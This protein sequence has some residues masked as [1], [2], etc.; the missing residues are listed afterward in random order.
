MSRCLPTSLAPPIP[1]L[2]R[3]P[4]CRLESRLAPQAGQTGGSST[5]HSSPLQIHSHAGS[6]LQTTL[7]LQM[8]LRS[9][10]WCQTAELTACSQEHSA[11]RLGAALTPPSH[12]RH[13]ISLRYRL[14]QFQAVAF[15]FQLTLP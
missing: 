9:E 14:Q 6:S 5:R 11:G 12:L 7:P 2:R 8:N 3:E 4:E 15:R 13:L 1:L 10:A